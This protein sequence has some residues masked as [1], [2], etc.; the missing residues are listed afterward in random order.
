MSIVG[1][2][3]EFLKEKSYLAQGEY[4]TVQIDSENREFLCE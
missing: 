2:T 4:K 1:Y 3:E